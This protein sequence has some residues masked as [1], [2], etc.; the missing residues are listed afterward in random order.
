MTNRKQKLVGLAGIAAAAALTLGA[1][2]AH[3]ASASAP[4]ASTDTD[5]H[6]VPAA[7]QVNGHSNSTVFTVGGITVTCTN[8]DAGGKT[9]ATGLKA[10]ALNPLPT[11][12]D[13]ICQRAVHR[14]RRR[15]GHDHHAA[16]SGP[17]ASRTPR[18]TRPEPSPTRVTS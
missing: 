13:G 2:G 18:T 16:A 4:R 15:H 5:D 14:Q 8:S 12:N 10:F 1:F 7:T 11:F 6:Y 3:T 17:S 9:P